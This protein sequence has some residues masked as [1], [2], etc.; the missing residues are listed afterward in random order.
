MEPAEA[1]NGLQKPRRGCQND[2]KPQVEPRRAPRRPPDRPGTPWVERGRSWSVHRHTH[3]HTI[4]Q[5]G[6]RAARSVPRAAPEQCVRVCVGV[7]AQGPPRGRLAQLSGTS[8]EPKYTYLHGFLMNFKIDPR[9][10]GTDWP[11]DIGPGPPPGGHGLV[12]AVYKYT[13]IKYTSIQYTSIKYTSTAYS[14]QYTV[15]S[16]CI[17]CTVYRVQGQKG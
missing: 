11:S 15:Y 10:L 8:W 12:R 13:S 7:H 16:I 5:F 3:T 4:A 6:P 17:Q 2:L 14:V 9:D 1:K